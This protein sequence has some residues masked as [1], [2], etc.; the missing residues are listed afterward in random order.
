MHR[1]RDATRARTPAV[2]SHDDASANAFGGCG[3]VRRNA[4]Y[5]SFRGALT[6]LERRSGDAKR[7]R[8][9]VFATST[10]LTTTRARE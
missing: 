8:D 6:R 3:L 4:S 5:S 2:A 1:A 10:T 7:G 9:H